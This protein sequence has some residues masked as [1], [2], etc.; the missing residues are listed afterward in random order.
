MVEVIAEYYAKADDFNDGI[1]TAMD[2]QEKLKT[3][4]I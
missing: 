2:R 4:K 3:I 1:H